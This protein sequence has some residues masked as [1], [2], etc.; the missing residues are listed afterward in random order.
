MDSAVLLG[1]LQ[2]IFE[3]LPVSSEGVV[4]VV[5][6][7]VYGSTLDE[8]VNY[9]LWLHIGT[10]PAA[11][12]ALRKEVLGIVRDVFARPHRF[13]P[14]LGYLV[15]STGVSGAVGFPLLLAL[16]ETPQAAGSSAM[17]LIGLL[18]IVTGLV[19]VRKR[20]VAGRRVDKLGRLDALLAGVAQGF[21]VLP[22]LSRSGLTVAVLLGRGFDR[23]NAFTVSFLMSVPAGVG[24]A[25]YAGSDSTVT[26]A[27]E[28]AVAA[29]VAFATG[30]VTIGVLLKLAAR[31]NLAAVVMAVG[32]T[33]LAGSILDMLS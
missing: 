29:L 14:L 2:G 31:L 4:A 26:M 24:A 23:K 21:S 19:Q 33:M 1:V 25:A 28:T 6:T 20:A 22:G 15:L 9:A 27:P 12:V 17:G 8:G 30:L 13:S 16:E 11:L 7:R 5:H 32:A 3:W 10:V 18:M